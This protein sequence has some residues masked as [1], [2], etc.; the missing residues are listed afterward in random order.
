[1][2]HTD[3]GKS[4]H[5][6]QGVEDQ[7]CVDKALDRP[8]PA[9]SKKLVSKKAV[10]QH[11]VTAP[12]NTGMMQSAGTRNQP[13]PDEQRH[14]H[15]RHA[16][17]RMLKMVAM[18]LIAPMMEETPTSGRRKGKWEGLPVCITNGG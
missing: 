13:G 8:P 18:M 4:S 9:A 15:Q 14:F 12:A 6:L 2:N 16:G 11:M 5:I 10:G 1:V 17:A 3:V 7:K